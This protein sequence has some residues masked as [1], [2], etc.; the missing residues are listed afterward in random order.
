MAPSKPRHDTESVKTSKNLDIATEG[1]YKGSHL[2]Q[3]RLSREKRGR[4]GERGNGKGEGA[5]VVKGAVE[6]RAEAQGGGDDR[7]QKQAFRVG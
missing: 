2:G 5:V 1:D 3:L 4:K 7:G 6:A